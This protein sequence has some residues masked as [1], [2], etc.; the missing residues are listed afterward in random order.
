M[1]TNGL[2]HET[3]EIHEREIQ[4]HECTRMGANGLNHETHEIHEK[5]I[6]NHECTRMYTNRLN[7][8]WTRMG[9]NIIYS[10][11]GFIGC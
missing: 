6:Q 9:T 2:N 3:H 5:K 10:L 4:N 7:H 11:Y 8:E 1:Y